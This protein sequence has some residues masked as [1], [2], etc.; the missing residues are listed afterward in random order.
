MIVF[1]GQDDHGWFA[2]ARDLLRG[3]S[4]GRVDDGAIQEGS[5][6]LVKTF[7]AWKI[8]IDCGQQAFDALGE[9]EVVMVIK[10]SFILSVS[11]PCTAMHRIWPRLK[12]VRWLC[13]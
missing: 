4:N 3:A 13:A 1:S 6:D 2:A 9:F 11:P 7:P 12:V 8:S 5:D 10:L